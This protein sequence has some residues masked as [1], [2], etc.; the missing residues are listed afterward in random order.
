MRKGLGES[1]SEHDKGSSLRVTLG[2]LYERKSVV[3]ASWQ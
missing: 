3:S 1:G 2:S